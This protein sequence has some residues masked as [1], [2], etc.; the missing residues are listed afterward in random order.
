MASK[1]QVRETQPCEAREGI[2]LVFAACL[3]PLI[4]FHNLIEETRVFY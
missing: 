1:V 2:S 3:G 4:Q